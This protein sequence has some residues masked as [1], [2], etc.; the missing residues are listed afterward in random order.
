MHAALARQIARRA[1][2]FAPP[3]VLLSGGE[4]TV[5][6]RPSSGAPG[7][8]GRASEFLLGCAVALQGE[9]GVHVLAA[10]TDGIDGSEENAGAF[11]D[12]DTLSR[13]AA[14]GLKPRAFLERNDA[15]GFFEALGDLLVTGPTFTNVND[16]R[17]MLIG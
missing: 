3:C 11:V 1:Q 8:G 9:P 15:Y 6:V 4:T 7:R 17:A 13:A 2:P 16:F 14:L 12:A 10:D 5:T